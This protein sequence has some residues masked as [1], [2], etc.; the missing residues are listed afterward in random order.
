MRRQEDDQH[1]RAGEN[2]ALRSRRML[3]ESDLLAATSAWD[4][5][6]P[7]F[8]WRHTSYEISA[9][10]SPEQFISLRQDL[11]MAARRSVPERYPETSSSST[12]AP[13][14]LHVV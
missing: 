7:P 9:D 12:S 3:T 14:H 2:E 4:M 10:S 13:R 8:Q 1:V 5:F 6:L 11:E